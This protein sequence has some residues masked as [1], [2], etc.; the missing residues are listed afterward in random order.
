MSYKKFLCVCVLLLVL[1]S[2]CVRKNPEEELANAL[3]EKE[4]DENAEILPVNPDLNAEA[5]ETV[6]V[7]KTKKVD[8]K[9][10]VINSAKIS[11]G[12]GG[13]LFLVNY[14]NSEVFN[15]LKKESYEK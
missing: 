6:P 11:E 1:F 7:Q 5:K 9:D 8:P 15:D 3:E 12:L 10:V 14:S 13:E 2:G 4:L